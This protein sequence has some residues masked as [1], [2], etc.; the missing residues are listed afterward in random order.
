MPDVS[1]TILANAKAGESGG[2]F[3]ILAGA[4]VG[5]AATRVGTP[6]PPAPWYKKPQ[7]LEIGSVVIA[8][9]GLVILIKVKK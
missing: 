2:V 6:K 7:V 5:F 9:I 4:A 8:I 1:N 3:G